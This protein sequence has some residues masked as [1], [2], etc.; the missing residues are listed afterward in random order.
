M[1]TVRPTMRRVGRETPEKVVVS[2]PMEVRAD[3]TMTEMAAGE[4]PE[5]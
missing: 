1:D 3:M 4:K 2:T 5:H